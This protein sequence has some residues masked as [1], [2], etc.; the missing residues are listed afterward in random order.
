MI[1]TQNFGG[2]WTSQ[3]LSCLKK[4]LEAYQTI[5]KKYRFKTVYVDAFAGSGEYK[6]KT[7]PSISLF[8]DDPDAIEYA[9][10][11]ARIALELSQPFDAYVFIDANKEYTDQLQVLSNDFPSLQSRIRIKTDDA[12]SY[13]ISIPK[14]MKANSDWRGVLFLDSYGA[15]LDFDTLKR[16]ADTGVF[17]V[18]YLF[19]LGM[20]LN[21]LLSKTWPLPEG[22]AN[23]LDLLLGDNGWR[24]VFYETAR[25]VPQVDIFGDPQGNYS[26]QRI[27]AADWDKQIE[28]VYERLSTIFP[29]VATPKMMKNSKNNPMF[30]LIFAA[31]NKNAADTAVKIAG[32]IL[33][34]LD[35]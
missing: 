22:F 7:D 2:E 27:K 5:M 15:K 10:G 35:K 16:I 13:L 19:P 28:Y 11:S 23:R 25:S 4:Y 12:N 21:R 29:K 6:P 26:E 18:W 17:D 31:S 8:N 30:L 20:G 34:S 1:M 9:K 33:D 24:D 3:K 14:I 32:A